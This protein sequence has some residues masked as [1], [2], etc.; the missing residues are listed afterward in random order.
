LDI[1]LFA[2][3]DYYPFG[4]FKHFLLLYRDYQTSWEMFE[5]SKGVIVKKGKQSNV[6]KKKDKKSLKIPDG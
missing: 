3:F 4:I 5:D 6:Q 2:L 1:A